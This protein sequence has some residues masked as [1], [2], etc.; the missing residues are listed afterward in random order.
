[1]DHQHCFRVSRQQYPRCCFAVD[2]DGWPISNHPAETQDM[3][4]QGRKCCLSL[5]C[6]TTDITQ[7]RCVNVGF[8]NH[9]AGK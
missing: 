9:P 6:W 4:P 7:Q 3:T 5:T 8:P 1:M 2:Q